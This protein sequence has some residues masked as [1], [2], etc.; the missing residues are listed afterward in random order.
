MVELNKENFFEINE[1]LKK[2]YKPYLFIFDKKK[3]KKINNQT[4][5][6]ISKNFKRDFDFSMSRNVYFIPKSINF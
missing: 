6:K 2:K 5:T 4:I 1:I 3:F